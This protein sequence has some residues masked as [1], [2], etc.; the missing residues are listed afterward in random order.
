MTGKPENRPLILTHQSRG[1]KD[2]SIK[3]G[4]GQPEVLR[5][6]QPAL[7]AGKKKECQQ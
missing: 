5:W 7:A 6:R 1:Q 4:W 2:G 3:V